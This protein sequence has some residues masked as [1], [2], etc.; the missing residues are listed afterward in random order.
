MSCGPKRHKS[1]PNYRINIFAVAPKHPL[2]IKPSGNALLDLIDHDS[3]EKLRTN[4]LG[5]LSVFSEEL[6]VELLT[7]ITNPLDLKNV[8]HCSRILYA[9]TYSEEYWRNLYIREYGRLEKLQDGA[10][11]IPFGNRGWKGTWRKSVLNMNEEALIQSKMIF[12]DLLYRPFQCSQIDYSYLFKQVIDYERKSSELCRTLNSEFGIERFHEE[13]FTLENFRSNYVNKP[14]ILQCDLNKN[15]WPKWDFD[16]LLE[17]FP[18][19]VFR[20]EAVQWKLSQYLAY[21]RNNRDESPLY[22][23]DCNSKTIEIVAKKYEPPN[24]F[25]SDFFKLFQV[26]NIHCRPDHRWLIAGPARSGSTFHKDPNQ[27]SAWNVVLSGIKLWILLPPDVSPPGVTADKDEEEVT[28]PI[29]ISEWIL[30]GFYN[31]AVKLAGAGKCLIGV[32]F[33]GECLYVPTGWWHSV[34]NI[35]DC[36][37]LT[38]NFV[39]EPIVGQVLNFFKNKTTQISGFH[40]KDVVTSVK[41]FLDSIE[42]KPDSTGS[43]IKVLQDFLRKSEDSEYDNEDC[44][45]QSRLNT[46][47][48]IYEFFVELIKQS[49]DKDVLPIALEKLREIEGKEMNNENKVSQT[50]N[51]LKEGSGQP[52]SFGFSVD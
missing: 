21:A 44:G 25:K 9:Y 52:F 15:R 42:H 20:Q 46:K 16:Q 33:P 4:L 11:I 49:K 39:P 48:P 6:L 14:F 17:L 35:T 41:S 34:I 32:T 47:I 23:F 45:V 30:S 10:D 19:E 51:K 26:E 8:S 24:I 7:Y 28:A 13:D 27:T 43:N 31:D 5:D 36:V 3:R 2:G 50:W 37:A 12:S 18:N 40:L 29:G 38:E 1:I 22:L